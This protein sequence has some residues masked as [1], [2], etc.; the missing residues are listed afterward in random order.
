MQPCYR[1]RSIGIIFDWQTVTAELL[2][3]AEL[4][5]DEQSAVGNV[6]PVLMD[7]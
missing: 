5:L 2:V 3:F 4:A 1:L 7:G 6:Q